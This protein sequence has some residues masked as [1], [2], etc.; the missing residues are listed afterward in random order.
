[1]LSAAAEAVHLLAWLWISDDSEGNSAS[2]QLF[3]DLKIS[4]TVLVNQDSEHSAGLGPKALSV[5][6]CVRANS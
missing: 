4:C 6:K 2:S 1:M 3:A 5:S